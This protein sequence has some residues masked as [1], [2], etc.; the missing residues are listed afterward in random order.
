MTSS[1]RAAPSRLQHLCVQPVRGQGAA[2]SP[3]VPRGAVRRSSLQGPEEETVSP[4]AASLSPTLC[5]GGLSVPLLQPGVVLATGPTGEHRELGLPP[6]TPPG[7]MPYLGPSCQI[8]R[9]CLRG[10][11]SRELPAPCSLRAQCTCQELAREPWPRCSHRERRMA[12]RA[13]EGRHHLCHTSPLRGCKEGRHR[14]DG[15]WGNA[16][17]G[18]KPEPRDHPGTGQRLEPDLPPVLT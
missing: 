6:S 4:R 13:P 14:E 18:Q 11:N 17:S 5:S 3:P 12:P 16:G 9:P 1:L 15:G 2:S 8:P 7:P 10:R